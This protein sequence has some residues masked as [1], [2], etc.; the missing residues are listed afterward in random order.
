MRSRWS[1]II[2]SIIVLLFLLLYGSRG[3]VFKD[4][5]EPISADS[6]AITA[7]F[8][9]EDGSALCDST[10]CFSYEGGRM[11]QALDDGGET[12]VSDLPRNGG[13]TLT[14]LDRQG[15]IQGNMALTLSEGAVIDAVT[16]ADGVGHITLRK[17]TEEIG[18]AF[19]LRDD[20]SLFC[21]LRLENGFV[22]GGGTV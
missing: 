3:R 2:L 20:G 21:A 15:E 5:E 4:P 11:N 9:R 14:V 22:T 7:S 16:D 13:M 8:L 18:L 10:A 1:K 17:D 19:T 6:L 12:E